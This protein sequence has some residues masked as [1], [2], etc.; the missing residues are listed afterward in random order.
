MSTETTDDHIRELIRKDFGE[1]GGAE[2]LARKLGCS[3]STASAM[4]SG[5]DPR[6]SLEKGAALYG[7]VAGEQPGTW[8][9]SKQKLNPRR[10]GYVRWSRDA[11]LLEF[12]RRGMNA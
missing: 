8:V 9:K 3:Q 12:V 6:V 2:R 10:M 1:H 11:A 4:R 5:R 7:Y